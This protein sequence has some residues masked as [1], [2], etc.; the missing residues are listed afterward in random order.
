MPGFIEDIDQL[1]TDI[2]QLKA[3]RSGPRWLT[4]Q[5]R[6]LYR[7]HQRAIRWLES[8]GKTYQAKWLRKALKDRLNHTNQYL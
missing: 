8:C 6:V 3:R 1:Q 4:N 5:A 2:V 7:D